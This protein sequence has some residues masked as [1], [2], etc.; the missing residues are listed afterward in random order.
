MLQQ[1]KIDFFF[2]T[3]KGS[4][5]TESK[6]KQKKLISTQKSANS[7]NKSIKTPKKMSSPVDLKRKAPLTNENVR[8]IPKVES[9]TKVVKIY[10]S[11][12]GRNS[13]FNQNSPE[14]LNSESSESLRIGSF[15]PKKSPR[16]LGGNARHSGKISPRK[17]FNDTELPEIMR[18]VVENLNLVKQGGIGPNDFDLETIYDTR[19]YNVRYNSLKTD[20]DDKYELKDVILPRETHAEHLFSIVTDVF[21][22]VI[23][24][25]YFDENEVDLVFS[26]LSMSAKA[27]MLFARLLKRKRTWYRNNILQYP[28]IDKDLN[29]HMRELVNK[30]F[31]DSK[32]DDEDVETLLKMLKVDEIRALCVKMKV[33]HRGSKATMME[34]LLLLKN[35]RKSWF[36]GAKCPSLMLRSM[37]NDALGACTKL[38]KKAVCIFDRILVLLYP[39]QDPAESI[40][41]LFFLLTKIKIGEVLYPTTPRERYPIFKN[42]DQLLRYVE[43]LNALKALIEST[44]N[45]EWTTVREIGHM[46]FNRLVP[47]LENETEEENSSLPSHVKK[48]SPLSVWTKVLSKSI[49]AFKKTPETIEFA[50]KY[51]RALIDQKNFGKSYLGRWYKE[52]TLIEMHHRKDLQTCATLT[53]HALSLENL[54]E[55]DIKELLERAKKLSRRKTGITAET[56]KLICHI[57]E[58]VEEKLPCEFDVVN[59][60]E[61]HMVQGNVTGSKSTWKVDIGEDKAF[62]KVENIALRH[63]HENGFIR[64]FH[65]EGS[66][67]LSLFTILFWN[68]LYTISVPGAFVCSYQETPLDLFTSKFFDNRKEQIESKIRFI[69]GLDNETFG[70]LFSDEYIKYQ[71]FKT[72]ISTN[73]FE[74]EQHVKEVAMCL[75]A[76]GV[77][78]ICEKLATNFLLWRSGFPDLFVWNPLS[79]E[80]K[81][82]EVKGPGDSLSCKQKLWLQYLQ[83][84]GLRAEVCIVKDKKKSGSAY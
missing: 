4:K 50:V 69:R 73:L 34:K 81:I 66:L 29:P 10:P 82:V 39:C 60:I 59:E 78:G 74:T 15:T 27:Q 25:G 3:L 30:G 68:E 63:Y 72:L 47:H 48:Y 18:D 84:I 53:L 80:C 52:L 54:T 38:S 13:Q 1:S 41:D 58:T 28:E 65:C 12:L 33:D 21:S 44:E 36:V 40:S 55:V 67:P 7:Q 16:S 46:A 8:K 57:L 49:D 70:E 61:A 43:A 62:T 19:N 11:P 77:S 45:K 17:L 24:C 31:C 9:P 6:G 79:N 51:L 2:P 83:Q 76:S 20:I 5:S 56:K 75:G 42:R 35:K 37:I 64:G 26:C 71:N 22:S 32:T 23:N 14:K